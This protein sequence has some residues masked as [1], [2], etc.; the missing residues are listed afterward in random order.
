MSDDLVELRQLMK[1]ALD[2]TIRTNKNI[3][4]LSKEVSELFK[5]AKSNREDIVI[6][7][8]VVNQQRERS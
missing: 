7:A 5:F 6:L 2:I 8:Q 3:L 1:E 4:T